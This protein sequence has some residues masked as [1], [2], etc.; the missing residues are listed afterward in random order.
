MYGMAQWPLEHEFPPHEIAHDPQFIGSV[1]KLTA[2]HWLFEQQPDGQDVESQ[3]Q[4]PPEQRWPLAHV[5]VVPLQVPFWHM[6]FCVQGSLS[7]HEPPVLGGLVQLPVP[8]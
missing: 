1:L 5:S 4:L 2:W 3:T 7:L 8:G 6:S